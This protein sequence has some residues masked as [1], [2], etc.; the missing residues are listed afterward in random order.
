MSATRLFRGIGVSAGVAWGPALII[1]W[2]FPEVPDR[3]VRDDQVDSEVRRLHEAVEY[4]V[5]HLRDM[6][7]RVLQRAGAE[8]SRIFDA[9]IL[10]AQD[11]EFLNSVETLIRN[12]QLSAETAYEFKALELRALWSG[13][14]RLRERLADLH[15]IQM[16]MIHR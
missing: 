2:D 14:A 4:V 3:P 6:G 8:E 5:S 1:R 16:R 13:A 7:E 9:Q 12:N 15:A 11:K 10:M